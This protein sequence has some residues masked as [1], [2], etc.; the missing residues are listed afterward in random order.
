V[1]FFVVGE[2]NSPDKRARQRIEELIDG[3][4]LRGR[5][6][7]RGY[8][9]D[10]PRLLAALDVYVSSSR[11]EAF[12][13][14]TLE[15]I[16]CGATVLATATDGSREIVA[17]GAAGRLVPVGDAEAMAAALVE[18]LGDDDERARLG[19]NARASVRERFS[20]ER[21]VAATEE[22][23]RSVLV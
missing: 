18:L 23:Y 6:H 10:L 1:D 20:L 8:T 5:V 12:G 19:A 11:A 9:P 21:M 14:A 2:D 13:L 16:V 4:N 15:A 7:L 17:D 3:A 22:V